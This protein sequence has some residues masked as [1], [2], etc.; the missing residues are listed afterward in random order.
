MAF[1]LV[2][3]IDDSKAYLDVKQYCALDMTKVRSATVVGD[4]SPGKVLA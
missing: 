2:V 3:F 1:V 4:S